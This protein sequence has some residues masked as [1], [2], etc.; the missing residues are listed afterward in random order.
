M[1]QA[2]PTPAPAST[3]RYRSTFRAG[4]FDGQTVVVTGG[5]SGLGRCTAHEL[6]SLGWQNFICDGTDIV[7][8]WEAPD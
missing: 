5:G 3:E 6:A 8:R 4:L 7:V 1:S 2:E